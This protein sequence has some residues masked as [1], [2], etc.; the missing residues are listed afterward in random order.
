MALFAYGQPPRPPAE[1]STVLTPCWSAARVLDSAWPYVS[2][3]WTPMDS[4]GTAASL[5]AV[6]SAL[7]WPGVATPIVSPSDSSSQPMSIRALAT[8]TTCATG[9]APSHGSPKHIERYPRTWAFS[10]FARATTGSNMASDSATVRFRLRAANVSVA[11]PNTA[12][13]RAPSAS[14]RSSP[15]SFG[16][17]T[18]RDT[19]P[20]SAMSPR[21]GNSCSASASWGTHFGCTKLVASIVVRPATARRRM[22]SAFTGVGTVPFSF[23]RPSRAP[24][25]WIRTREGRPGAGTFMGSADAV[26]SPP[27]GPRPPGSGPSRPSRPR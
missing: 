13:D 11:E 18:G 17:R 26:M 23:W 16:T 14:A 22:N 9:T 10:A 21:S 1:A 27:E 6:S 8:F 24:T 12:I 7:T 15:R 25:S 2:W 5:S 3:K 20:T 19:S 4:V